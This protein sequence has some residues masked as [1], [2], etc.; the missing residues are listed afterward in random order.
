MSNNHNFYC[1]K[2]K[3]SNMLVQ[4]PLEKKKHEIINDHANYQLDFMKDM[5]Y[6]HFHKVIWCIIG[7]V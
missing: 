7:I 5:K 2:S 3:T 4:A 1:L 6:M